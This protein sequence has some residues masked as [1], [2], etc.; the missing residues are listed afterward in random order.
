MRFLII[1]AFIL[2]CVAIQAC[3]QAA[4]KSQAQPEAS[5][6]ADQSTPQGQQT[7]QSNLDGVRIEFTD[8][9]CVWTISEAHSGIR[10]P[11]R[12]VI[13]KG[14]KGIIPLPMD[15]GGCGQPGASG[16]ILF[17]QLAGDKNKYCLCDGGLCPQP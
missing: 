9:R 2:F 11:Y 15:D 8:D 14:V 3:M 6:P 16:L 10:I 5:A 7:S 13:E 12:V 1:T 17:E 4:Q